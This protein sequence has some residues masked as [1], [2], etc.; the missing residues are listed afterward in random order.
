MGM[1]IT[2]L[3]GSTP[4]PFATDILCHKKCWRKHIL[5]N[6]NNQL[7]DFHLQNININDA[8]KLFF[9]QVDEVILAA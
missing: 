5:F 1:R 6:L 9:H 2:H 3:V 7:E 4:N 8:R